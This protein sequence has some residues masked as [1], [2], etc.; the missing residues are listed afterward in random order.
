MSMEQNSNEFIRLFKD[1]GPLF[2]VAIFMAMMFGWGR[3]RNSYKEH[4]KVAVFIQYIISSLMTAI[5]AVA[6]SLIL[7]LITHDA[8]PYSVQLGITVFVCMFGV[9]ALDTIAR[10]RLGFS[11]IDLMD[12]EDIDRARKGLSKEQRQKHYDNCPFREECDKCKGYNGCTHK[13]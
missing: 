9:K 13:K 1:L 7:P 12:P 2:A 11:I 3:V 10:K 8:V 4:D 6:T 5:L